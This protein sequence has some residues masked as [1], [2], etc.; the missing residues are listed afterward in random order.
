[1]PGKI[2]G[3]SS[4]AEF[5]SSGV[6]ASKAS[7]PNLTPS[8]RTTLEE[9]TA[10]SSSLQRRTLLCAVAGEDQKQSSKD[11]KTIASLVTAKRFPALLQPLA[12]SS[13]QLRSQQ[14]AGVTSVTYCRS[15]VPLAARK[16][17]IDSSEGGSLLAI[18][19][20]FANGKL[21]RVLLSLAGN[22]EPPS[23]TESANAL[24]QRSRSS[25]LLTG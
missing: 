3:N 18:T 22:L 13:L 5:S 23:Q 19:A 8:P 14:R 17:T 9:V 25:S 6:F 15:G 4:K 16:R 10:P 24:V 1:M 7:V 12:R 11:L 21:P 2:W 20:H